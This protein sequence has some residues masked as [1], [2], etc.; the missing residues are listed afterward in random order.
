MTVLL[1]FSSFSFSSYSSSSL[2]PSLSLSL[3]ILILPLEKFSLEYTSDAHF[4][5]FVS[6]Q[7]FERRH[8][9]WKLNEKT[10]SMRVRKERKKIVTSSCPKQLYFVILL[11]HTQKGHLDRKFCLVTEKKKRN[12]Q[13][14]DFT[15]SDFCT[16]STKMISFPIFL[17][18]FPTR[19][20]WEERK[21]E[22]R[23]SEKEKK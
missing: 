3:L 17:S 11:L 9:T 12:N 8:E 23:D 14:E 19:K 5:Y 1:P 18:F 21:R 6:C 4:R 13:N 20:I 15:C 2:S 16:T 10:W 22:K 7:R